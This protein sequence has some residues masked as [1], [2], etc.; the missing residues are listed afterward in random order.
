MSA[1]FAGHANGVTVL[2]T[3]AGIAFILWGAGR[4]GQR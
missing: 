3:L 4:A 1:Y 2:A